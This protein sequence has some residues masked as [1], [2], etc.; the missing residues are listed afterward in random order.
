MLLKRFVKKMVLITFVFILTASC[1]PK[2]TKLSGEDEMYDVGNDDGYAT[3]Y[4]KICEI[5][6]TQNFFVIDEPEN[7]CKEY[8]FTYKSGIEGHRYIFEIEKKSNLD[9]LE[10]LTKQ[11]YNQ[12]F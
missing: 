8:N 11:K 7:I 2:N 3:G 12:E 4:N 6:A 5:R 1:G 9:Y 10:M